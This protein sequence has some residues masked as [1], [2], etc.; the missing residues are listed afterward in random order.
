M[1]SSLIFK[2]QKIKKNQ[3]LSLILEGQVTIIRFYDIVNAINIFLRKGVY[4]TVSAT[5]IVG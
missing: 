3:M 5:V 1:Q 2:W 4:A